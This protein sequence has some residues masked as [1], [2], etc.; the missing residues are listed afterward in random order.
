MN[1]NESVLNES[2]LFENVLHDNERKDSSNLYFHIRTG[3]SSG[4]IPHFHV[5]N[6]VNPTKSELHSKKY[7]ECCIQLKNCGYW[8]HK[9]WHRPIPNSKMK[10]KIIKFIMSSNAETRGKTVWEHCK[11]IWLDK[12]PNDI[13]LK[14]MKTPPDY[15]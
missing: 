15:S 1:I 13:Q 11:D 9:P 2:Y 5:F 12:Y 10:Q 14:R 3:E 8:N 4:S 7:F 6:I